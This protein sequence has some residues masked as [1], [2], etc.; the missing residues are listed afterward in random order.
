M[1][2]FS[3]P[4]YRGYPLSRFKGKKKVVGK[5]AARKRLPNRLG[6]F[7]TNICTLFNLLN[8]LIALALALVGAWARTI[9]SPNRF[10][11]TSW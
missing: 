3:Q 11:Q 10:L 2:L 8:V 4:S 1:F 7:Y 5:T 9:I 6:K